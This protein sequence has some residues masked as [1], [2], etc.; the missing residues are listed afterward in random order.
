M[1]IKKNIPRIYI[2][3]HFNINEIYILSKDHIHY[4]HKVLRIKHEDVLE[5]FNDTNHI[6]FAKIIY[7]SNKIIKIKIF[8][9][10]F[11]NIE[12]PIHIH[13]GQ[14]I[15][16][17]DKK[18]DFIIQKSIE[19]GVNIITPLLSEN[20]YL[21]KKN[22]NIS[23]KIQRWKKIAIA[24]CQQCKRNIIP[25]IRHPIDIFSWCE[26]RKHDTKIIFHPESIMTI[27]Q[28]NTPLKYIRIIIGSEQGFSYN[29]I[30]KIIQYGFISIKLG[31]RILRTETAAL[32][33]VTALQLK[34]GDL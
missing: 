28:L 24:T 20:F 18:M 27:H 13:L 34:F 19:M 32:V 22:L 14:L 26:K 12:S 23:N 4:L 11:K 33:S 6:F 5:I 2:Q 21:K 1:K 15:P 16:K 8:L 31:P 29:E 10:Q 7:M 30:Q 9:K 3:E 17:N 25:E